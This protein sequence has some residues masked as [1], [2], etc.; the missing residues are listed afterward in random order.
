MKSGV[1]RPTFRFASPARTSRAICAKTHR[2]L[3]AT[4]L[5]PIC[6]G[7]CRNPPQ[8]RRIQ[9]RSTAESSSQLSVEAEICGGLACQMMICGGFCRNPPRT[10][11]HFAV[12][13]LWWV[14]VLEQPKADWKVAASFGFAKEGGFC[15]ADASIPVVVQGRGGLVLVFSCFFSPLL[16]AVCK[17]SRG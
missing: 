5:R 3:S 2:G 13:C 6:G 1:V 9:C 7:F 8:I 10:S 12:P 14:L 17:A 4:L 11:R 16:P 15:S